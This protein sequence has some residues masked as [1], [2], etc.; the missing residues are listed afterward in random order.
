MYCIPNTTKIWQFLSN[1][2]FLRCVTVCFCFIQVFL[3]FRC[4][5]VLINVFSSVLVC[6]QD[7]FSHNRFITFQ[8]RYTYIAFTQNEFLYKTIHFKSNR[9]PVSFSRFRIN[10]KCFRLRKSEKLDDADVKKFSH[11]PTRFC[12]TSIKPL[13]LK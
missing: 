5:P 12:I 3:Y 10:A 11:T 4:F 1:N 7:V 6:I 9:V 8:Q 13:A 2:P